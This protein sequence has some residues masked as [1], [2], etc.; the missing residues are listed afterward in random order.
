[1][2]KLFF[3]AMCILGTSCTD[4]Q[5]S[6][7]RQTS[8]TPTI[9]APKDDSACN[10]CGNT[11][12]GEYPGDIA[13]REGKKILDGIREGGNDQKRWEIITIHSDA[14]EPNYLKLTMIKSIGLQMRLDPKK[15]HLSIEKDRFNQTF[16]IGSAAENSAS[17]C[18][19]Y[20]INILDA[21]SAYALIKKT[22]LLFEYRHDRFSMGVEY[23]LYDME[24]AAMRS[25]WVGGTT[26]KMSR[27][28]Q[29]KPSPVIKK[30]SNGYQFDWT[31]VDVSDKQRGKYSIHN[32]YVRV[33]DPKSKKMSLRCTD[34]AVPKGEGIEND[35][36][37][38]DGLRLI[39]DQRAPTH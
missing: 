16:E 3:V 10:P 13:E 38:G 34:M 36:C 27:L 1:M 26:D 18:P 4:A 33:M 19:K 7:P 37:G 24:T 32:K 20:N 39:S 28:P 30:L 17:T 5:T 14:K 15:G 21:S 35:L 6:Q 12:T 31:G 9:V 23:F 29:A 22:C 8:S 2:K 25:M 11:A